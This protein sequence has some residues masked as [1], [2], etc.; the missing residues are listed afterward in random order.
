MSDIVNSAESF[1]QFTES[2]SREKYRRKIFDLLAE[3]KAPMTD[4]E[5]MNAL[6]V[7]DPNLI[8]PEITR[9]REDGVVKGA[10]DTKCVET[11]RKVRLSELSGIPYE[12]RKPKTKE[13]AEDNS[14]KIIVTWDSQDPDR[15]PRV[16]VHR[17]FSHMKVIVLDRS[18]EHGGR[19][20][21]TAPHDI[22]L[23]EADSHNGYPNHIEIP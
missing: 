16:Y 1:T 7:T 10:G 9:L 15:E 3:R 2:G 23:L 12:E 6:S 14:D 22:A 8:R 11:G 5:M 19:Y 4:R 13:M 20:P 18:E 17:D 21:N